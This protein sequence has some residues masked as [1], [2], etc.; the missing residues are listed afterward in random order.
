M[1]LMLK[2]NNVN[3]QKN[4]AFQMIKTKL[5]QL[6]YIVKKTTINQFYKRKILIIGFAIVQKENQI[7]TPNTA[8][9]RAT[10]T[11]QSMVIE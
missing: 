8:Q 1:R 5:I 10:T 3:T 11:S 4:K 6:S 9:H 2:L 7:K